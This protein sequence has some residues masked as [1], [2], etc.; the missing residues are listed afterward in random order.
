MQRII[1]PFVPSQPRPPLL[2]GNEPEARSTR[3]LL[4]A[5]SEIDSARVI[6]DDE[7]QAVRAELSRRRR[8]RPLGSAPFE[9]DLH[10][11]D[12]DRPAVHEGDV[13]RIRHRG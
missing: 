7:A 3:E 4:A 13:I 6:L 11:G 1:T 8:R 2:H 5:L 9:I 10:D 12:R